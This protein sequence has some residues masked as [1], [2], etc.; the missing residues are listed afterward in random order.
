MVLRR[1]A[2]HGQFH[3]YRVVYGVSSW[4]GRGISFTDGLCSHCAA[5]LHEALEPSGAESAPRR[6]Q[7]VSRVAPELAAIALSVMVTVA[8]LV[9]ARPLHLEILA[10][11]LA[12]TPLAVSSEAPAPPIRVAI[13]P[14]S[15]AL[16]RLFTA[17]V[18]LEPA[19]PA[20]PDAGRSRLPE[21]PEPP[22]VADTPRVARP[23]ALSLIFT[24]A[25]ERAP[26]SPPSR[27]LL[28]LST[29]PTALAS[30]QA[31]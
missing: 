21:R 14:A 5:A 24:S 31:P 13:R 28:A 19:E 29:D 10:G 26:S 22:A 2:W 1:C 3:G 17:K 4:R 16:P 8:G 27:I 23:W 15:E 7:S 11:M 18:D 12:E 20:S 6:W 9:G 30:L 25:G